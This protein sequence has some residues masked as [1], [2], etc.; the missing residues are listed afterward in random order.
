MCQSFVHGLVVIPI[1]LP[2]S[3]TPTCS[4]TLFLSCFH[5]VYNSTPA[6]AIP[7]ATIPHPA[8]TLV[9]A[10]RAD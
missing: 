2:P 7:T 8:A 4:S 1:S 6:V 9:R 5:P 10:K 3:S